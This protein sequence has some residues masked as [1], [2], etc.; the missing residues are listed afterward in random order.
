MFDV[1]TLQEL[2]YS[3]TLKWWPN[4]SFHLVRITKYTKSFLPNLHNCVCIIRDT[5]INT[6]FVLI[7]SIIEK[8]E[9]SSIFTIIYS[10][11]GVISFSLISLRLICFELDGRK[12]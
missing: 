5:N 6:N 2:A 7:K 12:H 8:R 9:N 10:P 4:I 1:I 11:L 3:M